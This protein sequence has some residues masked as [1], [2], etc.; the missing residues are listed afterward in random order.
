MPKKIYI[1]A[2]MYVHI[3]IY[4]NMYIHIYICI[5]IYIERKIAKPVYHFMIISSERFDLC[6]SAWARPW[7]REK[8]TFVDVFRLLFRYLTSCTRICIKS[9]I[10]VSASKGTFVNIFRL[11]GLTR[12]TSICVL[13]VLFMYV[14]PKGH[15]YMYLVFYLRICTSKGTSIYVLK[16]LFMGVPPKG[17]S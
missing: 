12:G 13:E 9:S 16:V 15:S 7:W 2:C 17:H 1:Y 3:H 10:Y 4:M 8:G 11:L 14:T 5:N 6:T